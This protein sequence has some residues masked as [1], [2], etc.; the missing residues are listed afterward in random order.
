MKSSTAVDIEQHLRLLNSNVFKRYVIEVED[1]QMSSFL[2]NVIISSILTLIQLRRTM[3][4]IIEV[5]DKSM[6]IDADISSYKI[7]TMKLRMFDAQ[8]KTYHRIHR[9]LTFQLDVET[10]ENFDESHMNMTTHRQLT[11]V[12][13]NSKLDKFT[14]KVSILIKSVNN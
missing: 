14:N 11:H 4:N 5:L 13:L 10:N 1:E 3:T 12:V 9:R 6:R 7:V 2:I 8:S